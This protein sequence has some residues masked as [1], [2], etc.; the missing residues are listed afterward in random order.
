M[1]ESTRLIKITEARRALTEAKAIED[2]KEIRDRAAAAEMYARQQRYALDVQNDGAEIRLRAQQ[3]AGEMLRQMEKVHG[4]RGIP[5]N[6]HTLVESHI[7]T[8][9]KLA[10]LGISKRQS[11][12]WQTMAK[13]EDT[14]PGALDDHIARVRAQG[15][16]LT[17]AGVLR[18]AERFQ[19]ATR[20][21]V[22]S[23]EESYNTPARYLD[24]ARHVMG[25]IDIDPA[26]NA[27]SQET[28]C[29]ATYYTADDDGLA[30]AWHGT[31]WLNPPYSYPAVEQFVRK[32][33]ESWREGSVTAAIVLVNNCTD[34]AWFQAAAVEASA[35]CFTYGRINFYTEAREKTQPTQGQAFFYFGS[36]VALFAERFG[37][38]GLIMRRYAE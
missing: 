30:Q 24:A 34:T 1:S 6:E 15:E 28:V 12:D 35:I 2:V 18:Q 16:R 10:D 21:T 36:H 5:G 14:A 29:A 22:L 7:G 31:V 13:M 33:W 8:P 9:P 23:G 3:K 4:A 27:L 19:G 38:F 26:S 11:S 25:T 17:D 37:E 32:C 20:V